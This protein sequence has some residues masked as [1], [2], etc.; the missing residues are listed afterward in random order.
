MV[1]ARCNVRLKA[2]LNETKGERRQKK[3]T[4]AYR[5]DGDR[6]V[7]KHGKPCSKSLWQVKAL[8]WEGV[9]GAVFSVLVGQLSVGKCRGA[10]HGRKQ[11]AAAELLSSPPLLAFH[12]S[13]RETS[14]QS[15]FVDV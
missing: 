4:N 15:K 6:T 12:D 2:R 5:D 8:G 14:G 13:S 1:D 10:P 7:A 11:Q 3:K 9:F